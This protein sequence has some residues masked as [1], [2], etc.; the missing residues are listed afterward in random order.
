MAQGPTQKSRLFVTLNGR[1]RLLPCGACL[2]HKQGSFPVIFTRR[3]PCGACLHHKQGSFPVIFTRCLPCGACLHPKQGSFPVIFTR[4]LP[5]CACLHPKQGSF[6]VIFYK[7]PA[8]WRL[9]GA[10]RQIYSA[11]E[12]PPKP[13]DLRLAPLPAMPSMPGTAVPGDVQ[14]VA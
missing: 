14:R 10:I 7:A 8:V 6:P 12:L 11:V 9:F 13:C 4:R 2:H 5:C 3:L 1:S